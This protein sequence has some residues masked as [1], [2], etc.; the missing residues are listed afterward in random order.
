MSMSLRSTSTATSARAAPAH[1]RMSVRVQARTSSWAPGFDLPAH[2]DGSMVGDFGFDPLFLGVD[3]RKREWY[4][5]AELIHGR[6]AMIGVAG[7]LYKDVLSGLGIGG[8]AADVEWFNAGEAAVSYEGFPPFAALF[9]AQIFLTGWVEMRRLQDLQAPGSANEDPVFS[10]NKLTNS[11]V[12]YPGIDPL[13][14]SKGKDIESLKLKEIKNG[15]LAMLA[16]AGFC[17]QAEV[18]GKG[19]LACLSDHLASP[20]TTTVWNNNHL[21]YAL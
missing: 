12:G 10:G 9:G 8:P 16:F 14:F 20:L 1:T 4:R 3:A 18:T 21:G 11:D 6:T 2:L 7:I 13:G 15:R 17:A 5:Q 19:P